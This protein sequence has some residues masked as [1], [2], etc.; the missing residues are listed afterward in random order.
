MCVVALAWKAH[1]R[2]TLVL[3]AN[4]DEFHARP[5]APLAVWPGEH[6]LGGRDLQSGGMWLGVSSIGRL[7]VITNVRNPDGPDPAKATRGALV[8]DWLEQGVIDPD[9]ARYNS[10]HLI[11][12]SVD[13]AQWL[14]NAPSSACTPL[15]PGMHAVSNGLWDEPWPRKAIVADGMAR[16]LASGAAPEALFGLLADECAPGTDEAPVFIRDSLYGTRAS[17]LVAI[18][19]GGAGMIIERRFAAGGEPAGETRIDFRWPL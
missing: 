12:A 11:T 19:A 6:V 18:D 15:E 10:F 16:W 1:P 3:A 13:S 4:R 14:T 7:A 9:L 8:Q 17:T 2:W 5:S